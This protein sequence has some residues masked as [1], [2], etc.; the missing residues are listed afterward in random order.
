MMGQDAG[1]A[2]LER[3]KG[4]IGLSLAVVFC[5]IPSEVCVVEGPRNAEI[6]PSLYS[7]RAAN[8]RVASAA[9]NNS[10]SPQMRNPPWVPHLL[11]QG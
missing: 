11:G 9:T 8:C 1:F 5:V 7:A 2:L 10:L 6:A 3:V 4:K